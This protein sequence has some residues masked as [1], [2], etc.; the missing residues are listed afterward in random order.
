MAS[1]SG[2]FANARLGLTVLRSRYVHL[3]PDEVDLR[4]GP[5]TKW[6][7]GGGTASA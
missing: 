7:F 3:R 1:K 2:F 5:V 6:L 4:V